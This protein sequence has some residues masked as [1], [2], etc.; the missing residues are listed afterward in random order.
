M[1][2]TMTCNDMEL[3]GVRN[4]EKETEFSNKSWNQ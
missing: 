3:T 2:L 1:G 4:E